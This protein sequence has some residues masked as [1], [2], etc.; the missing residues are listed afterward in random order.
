VSR[1]LRSTV[2]ISLIWQRRPAGR[3]KSG[4]ACGRCRV[5]GVG[6]GVWGVGCGVWGGGCGVWGVGWK[7]GGGA[8]VIACRGIVGGAAATKR[9]AV[10]PCS[11][12]RSA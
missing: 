10:C 1:S 8:G 2:W 6:C 12:R 9:S 5:W 3:R 7:E 11:Y 4:G